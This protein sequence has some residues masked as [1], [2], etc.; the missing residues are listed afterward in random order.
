MSNECLLWKSI[1]IRFLLLC[2]VIG[3]NKAHSR[4]LWIKMWMYIVFFVSM[5]E[6]ARGVT[7]WLRGFFGGGGGQGKRFVGQKN[8]PFVWIENSCMGCLFVF[9]GS[10][11]QC[12]KTLYRCFV[13][14]YGNKYFQPWKRETEDGRKWNKVEN[15]TTDKR[16]LS[17]L[18]VKNLNKIVALIIS[19]WGSRNKKKTLRSSKRKKKDAV[20]RINLFLFLFYFHHHLSNFGPYCIYCPL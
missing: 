9:I 8:D 2:H 16:S 4:S 10:D 3:L 5:F 14:C 15:V 20:F 17:A 18:W 11:G 6:R 1:F 7:Y 13:E 12:I 19:C